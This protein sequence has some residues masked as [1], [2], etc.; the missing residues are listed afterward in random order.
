MFSLFSTYPFVVGFPVERVV[1][2]IALEYYLLPKWSF[3][4]KYQ[5]FIKP[6]LCA[7]HSRAVVVSKTESA[8]PGVHILTGFS[9]TIEYQCA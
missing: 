5:I 2:P 8:R 4:V 3:S 7:R 6:L 9:G 1:F